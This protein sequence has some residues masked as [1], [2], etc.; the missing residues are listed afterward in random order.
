M[1]TLTIISLNAK[2]VNIPEKRRILHDM[3]RLRADIVLL[4]ETHF[5]DEKL[6]ILK[7][8]YYPTVYHSSYANAKSR[9][10]SILIAA[11]VPWTLGDA[12][13]D[14]EAICS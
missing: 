2:G 1:D 8:R 10:V 14:A 11:G 7:N 5:S 3:R 12:K 4:Q 6:P 9:G 13:R